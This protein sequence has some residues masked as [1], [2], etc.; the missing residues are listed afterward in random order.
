MKKFRIV[1]NNLSSE[2]EKAFRPLRFRIEQYHHLLFGLIHW[3]ETPEF[4]PPHNF[5]ATWEAAYA[6][7]EHYPDAVIYEKYC[8]A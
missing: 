6:I 1:R 2:G 3:W 5:E 4:A 7:W 8:K